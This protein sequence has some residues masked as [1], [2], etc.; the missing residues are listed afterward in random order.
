[1]FDIICIACVIM[2]LFGIA[3]AY[4]GYGIVDGMILIAVAVGIMVYF[5][6]PNNLSTIESKSP[7]NVV[8]VQDA[9]QDNSCE[10]DKPACY[11]VEPAEHYIPED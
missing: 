8:S 1:V 3:R 2:I 9:V 7:Q 5:S 10:C 11:C 6:D 4:T